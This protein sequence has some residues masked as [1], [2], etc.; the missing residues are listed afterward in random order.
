MAPALARPTSL[1]YPVVSGRKL[2][3]CLPM[4]GAA[5]DAFGYSVSLSG[6]RALVGS[7]DDDDHGSSSGSA[8]LF[9]LSGGV[10]SQTS[11][12]TASDGAVLDRFGGAVSISGNRALVGARYDDDNGPGS[13]SGFLFDVSPTFTI[14]GMVSGLAGSGLVVQNDNGDDLGIANNGS[15]TFSTA[16]TDGS[17]YSVSVMTQPSNLSQMCTVSN[18]SGTVSGANV[19][20]V[21]I[22]CTTN[23]FSISG[24][25]SG[26]AGSGLSLQNNNGGRFGGNDRWQLHV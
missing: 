3:N 26:L 7:R 23:T 24:M 18:G 16:I 6:D 15:F 5:V 21:T 19:I 2:Q 25:V 9:D 17:T 8:Y 11:K 10:W 13:G 20:D 1:I 22:A 4:M 12:M 14:G